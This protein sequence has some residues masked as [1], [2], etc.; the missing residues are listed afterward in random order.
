LK[1]K[2][3]EA[4]NNAAVVGIES[5]SD[6]T[7]NKSWRK[8]HAERWEPVPLH[9]GHWRCIHVKLPVAAAVQ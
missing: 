8:P 6:R 9:K 2:V 5:S 1:A 4:N 3:V 7:I